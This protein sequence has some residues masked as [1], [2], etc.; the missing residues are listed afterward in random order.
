MDRSS[1]PRRRRPG[2]PSTAIALALLAVALAPPAARAEEA[3]GENAEAVRLHDQG[4]EQFRAGQFA[5]AA[6]SFEA[7]QRLAPSPANLNNLARCY[8]QLGRI[9][10]AIAALDVYLEDPGLPP[11]RIERA[12]AFRSRLM[13][14]PAQVLVSSNPAGAEVLVNGHPPTVA[15]ATTPATLRLEPGNHVIEVRLA[16]SEPGRQPIELQPGERRELTFELTPA[17]GATET[18]PTTEAPPT[19][20]APPTTARS[21]SGPWA[22]IGVG[23]GLALTGAVVDTVALVQSRREE[24]FL[25]LDEYDEWR[26][27]VQALAISGDV[28]LPL[29]GA[30]A[31]AGLIWLLVD[32]RHHETAA[33]SGATLSVSPAP[34][35]AVAVCGGRF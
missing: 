30:M 29:G 31:V 2:A 8:E 24:P 10:D 32:R 26:T 15:G 22:L 9:G 6:E 11:D 33:G 18:P 25:D 21:S 23:L 1:E 17:P 28:L 14:T 27:R 5:E 7:A 16:G 3:D 20:E 19:A 13:A 34:G 12:Q 4:L 35:G